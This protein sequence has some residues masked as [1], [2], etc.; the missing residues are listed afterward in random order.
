M[1]LFRGMLDRLRGGGEHSPHGT[2]PAVA[3]V[4]PGTKFSLF[5]GILK[6]ST[7]TLFALV[8]TL[9]LAAS[10]ITVTSLSDSGSGSL[11]NAIASANTGDSIVF[12]AALS[13]GTILLTSGQLDIGAGITINGTGVS[14]NG[15]GGAIFDLTAATSDIFSNLT[16][17][18][19]T[20]AITGSSGA[21]L[22]L[23]N[24]TISGSTNNALSN[25]TA[26]V[27]NSTL[28]NN[29]T[30]VSGGTLTLTGST[31]SGNS[32]GGLVNANGTVVNST[33]SGNVAAINGGT[34]SLYDSTISG[35]TTGVEN[36]SLTLGNSIIAGNTTDLGTGDT[37]T[38]SGSN[39]IGVGNG[40]GLLNGANGDIVGSLAS[41][42]N[43]EL[44]SLANNGGPTETE[45]LLPGSPAID[46]GNNLIIPSG[47]MTDQRGAGFARIFG[48]TV[49]IGAFEVQPATAPEPATYVT[50]L[51]GVAL[52]AAKLR[53]KR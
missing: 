49:D 41:P 2:Q 6:L 21:S 34:L 16:L 39:L 29:A 47:V 46:S 45:A 36:T 52:L 28:S 26:T 37:F 14:I 40:S 10:V 50:C 35:G 1:L 13:G 20:N 7:I 48:G 27:T 5:G 19:A 38:D 24:S 9:P 17:L 11:R 25:V 22:T 4:Y 8:A 51:L 23:T 15:N 31:I 30:A 42:V 43:P 53:W 12:A 44:G 32:T 3:I 33:F 18:S